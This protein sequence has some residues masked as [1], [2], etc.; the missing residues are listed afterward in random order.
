LVYRIKGRYNNVGI[1]IGSILES[2]DEVLR[3]Y[4][5]TTK[6]NFNIYVVTPYE[7]FRF[8]YLDLLYEYVTMPDGK[9]IDVLMETHPRVQQMEYWVARNPSYQRVT[10]KTSMYYDPYTYR[11][12]G[13]K[14]GRLLQ[15]RADI[16]P[17]SQ[18]R[19]DRGIIEG[20]YNYDIDNLRDQRRQQRMSVPIKLRQIVEKESVFKRLINILKLK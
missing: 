14:Y 15:L 16:S 7:T 6:F 1:L 8:T 10:R 20:Y 5:L 9:S 3:W 18:E 4:D 17:T 2:T 13:S 12:N 11:D 19:R